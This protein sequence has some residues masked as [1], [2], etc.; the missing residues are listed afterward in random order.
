LRSRREVIRYGAGRFRQLADTLAAIVAVEACRPGVVDG[1][2]LG[3][4]LQAVGVLA[5]DHPG[6]A[7]FLNNLRVAGGIQVVDEVACN[8]AVCGLCYAVAI[9]VIEDLHRAA[10]HRD[11]MVLAVVGEALA[12]E[13]ITLPLES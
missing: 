11:E 4:T 3:D 5:P 1:L 13:A 7:E 6:S 10:V 12:A 9:A 8:D 2:V